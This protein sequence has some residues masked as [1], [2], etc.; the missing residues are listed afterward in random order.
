MRENNTH[1]RLLTRDTVELANL[2]S[3]PCNVCSERLLGGAS[4]VILCSSD[5]NLM[6]E[7]NTHRRL[8]TRD[9]VELANLPS[10]PC[11]VCSERLL[12]GASFVILAVNTLFVDKTAITNLLYVNI[13]IYIFRIGPI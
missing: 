1:R 8:L 11:N 2:P 7:N 6:R 13:S 3:T 4:F 9:T 5:L 12:G 10:T